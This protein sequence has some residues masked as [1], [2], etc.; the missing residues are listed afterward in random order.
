MFEVNIK[1]SIRQL[2][3]KLLNY[4]NKSVA[5]T[6]QWLHENKSISAH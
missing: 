3:K 5:K 6:G 4:S 1:T 2:L